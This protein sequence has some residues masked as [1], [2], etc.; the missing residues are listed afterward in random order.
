MKTAAL[1]K[2]LISFSLPFPRSAVGPHPPVTVCQRLSK[3]YRKVLD[4]RKKGSSQELNVEQKELLSKLPYIEYALLEMEAF[5][6]MVEHIAK[7]GNEPND[8]INTVSSKQTVAENNVAVESPL[9]AAAAPLKVNVGCQTV[10]VVKKNVYTWT[11]KINKKDAGTWTKKIKKKDA[12]TDTVQ[13]E[14]AGEDGKTSDSVRRAIHKLLRTLQVVFRRGG[15][16]SSIS[17][18]SSSTN[19]CERLLSRSFSTVSET[20]LSPSSFLELLQTR[21]D[22]AMSYILVEDDD[23]EAVGGI[24]K[25]CGEK[26]KVV[27]HK[28]KN[29]SG[30]FIDMTG[31][32]PPNEEEDQ[33]Q[34][35]LCENEG[36]M[37]SRETHRLLPH[38]QAGRTSPAVAKALLKGVLSG[39]GAS[40]AW[41]GEPS[42]GGTVESFDPSSISATVI[43]GA[44][45]SPPA[46]A[47][48][49]EDTTPPAAAAA[50]PSTMCVNSNTHLL[51]PPAV[52]ARWSEDMEL[53]RN[54]QSVSPDELNPFTTSPIKYSGR[55]FTVRSS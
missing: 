17:F 45:S 55:S 2:C 10:P 40:H 47:L 26:G 34:L 33:A 48:A 29:Q 50:A 7:E 14:A 41:G 15:F 54:M 46:L 44:A 32:S 1:M 36:A 18:S 53:H 4:L 38:E 11:E 39:S 49:S 13:L 6:K 42:V 35:L 25:E 28:E 27:M 30:A 37:K 16:S 19:L 52:M 3:K 21:I 9:P 51:E 5:L 23:L 31:S 24:E 22:E 8:E 12:G 20:S 43:N